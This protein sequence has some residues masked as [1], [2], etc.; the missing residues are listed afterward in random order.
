MRS[1]HDYN[2]TLPSN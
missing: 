1:V 2:V